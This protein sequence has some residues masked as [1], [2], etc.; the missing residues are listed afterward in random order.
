M[1]LSLVALGERAVDQDR[2]WLEARGVARLANVRDEHD[3][4]DRE[5][6]AVHTLF[7]LLVLQS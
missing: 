3:L 2:R 6:P 7:L 4:S 5:R 1:R